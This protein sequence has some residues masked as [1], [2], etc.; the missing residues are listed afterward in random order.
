MARRGKDTHAEFEK[1]LDEW[2]ELLSIAE[3]DLVEGVLTEEKLDSFYIPKATKLLDKMQV[4]DVERPE[5]M[6]CYDNIRERLWDND[7]ESK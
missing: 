4:P 2:S 7:D 1:L 5:Y 6:E 3:D